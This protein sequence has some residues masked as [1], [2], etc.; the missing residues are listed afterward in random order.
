MTCPCNQT[1]KTRHS[2]LESLL[3]LTLELHALDQS[4]QPSDAVEHQLRRV[5]RELASMSSFIS[6]SR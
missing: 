3:N 1:G 4:G 2:L 6:H 5:H